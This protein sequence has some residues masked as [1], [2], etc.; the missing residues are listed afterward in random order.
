MQQGQQGRQGRSVGRSP[1][2]NTP[3]AQPTFQASET[4]S[5]L[6]KPIAPAVAAGAVAYG[7]YRLK[8]HVDE[9]RAKGD[10]RTLAESL[11]L[12]KLPLIQGNSLVTALVIAAAVQGGAFVV[13][14]HLVTEKVMPQHRDS[15]GNPRTP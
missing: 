2:H 1:P 13:A 6:S 14:N 3:G 8:Q 10:K 12:P 7:F 5:I 4:M 9:M 11:G 15:L